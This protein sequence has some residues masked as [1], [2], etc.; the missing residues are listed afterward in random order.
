MSEYTKVLPHG[1]FGEREEEGRRRSIGPSLIIMRERGVTTP[2][3]HPLLV[4][5]EGFAS[6]GLG[7]VD[8]LEFV[9]DELQ[10]LRVLDLTYV[11]SRHRFLS[12]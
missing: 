6:I 5:V 8:T 1:K 12:T 10:C 3:F 4:P 2:L 9:V 11:L 7:K